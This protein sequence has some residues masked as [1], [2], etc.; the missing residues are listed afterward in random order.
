MFTKAIN[1]SLL[2]SSIQHIF[3]D[4][5]N[6][7]WDFETNSQ[8]VLHELIQKHGL[9]SKCQC[10]D[11]SFIKT[12]VLVNDDLWARY[13][14]NLISKEELRSSRFY[15]TML[16]FGYEDRELGLQLEKEY[17]DN[18]PYQKELFPHTLETLDYLSSKY[19]LH[20]ITN[21][22]AEIQ[23]IKLKNCSIDQYFNEVLISEQ[24]GFNKPH[25]NIFNAALEKTS[26]KTEHALMIGDDWDADI[27]GAS[28][29]GFKTI[30][31]NPRKKMVNSNQ[32]PEIQSLNELITLL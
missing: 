28:E 30:F 15:N 29:A 16:Y 12:Y 17:I 4:L 24:I 13:R 20:I 6:T 21:G 7:L 19:K 32:T 26:A 23:H 5:D 2:Y 10:S 9:I 22:F 14:K 1:F 11:R 8:K 27:I 18:S 3:F 25:P 31:F